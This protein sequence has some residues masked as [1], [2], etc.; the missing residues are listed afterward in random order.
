VT[1]LE[2]RF[3]FERWVN[4]STEPEE[5]VN[6]NNLLG[7]PPCKAVTMNAMVEHTALT[8][9]FDISISN[10]KITRIDPILKEEFPFI[11]EDLEVGDELQKIA[12]QFDLKAIDKWK[13]QFER[14][15]ATEDLVA[16]SY[17]RWCDV[18]WVL[19]M[20]KHDN[21]TMRVMYVMELH[22]KSVGRLLLEANG[23]VSHERL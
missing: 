1:D 8:H 20:W 18:D 10:H 9:S 11:F 12:F 23:S 14:I 6:S 2:L 19:K 7:G 3:A 15:V 17:M 13:G 5:S 22:Q 21:D 16:F 4:Q